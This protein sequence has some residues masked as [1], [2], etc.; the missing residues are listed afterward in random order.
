MNALPLHDACATYAQL[1]LPSITCNQ[2]RQWMLWCTENGPLIDY[3][4]RIHANQEQ[5]SPAD[6][7]YIVGSGM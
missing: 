6:Q 3:G 2:W 4:G 7:Q 5:V 1:C